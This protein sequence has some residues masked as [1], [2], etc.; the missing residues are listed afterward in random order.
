MDSV[1]DLVDIHSSEAFLDV[2]QAI[3]GRMRLTE[4]VWDQGLHSRTDEQ[5][6]IGEAFP[7]RC[8][9]R[10]AGYDGVASF[11]EK[12]QET[13]ADLGRIHGKSLAQ[14]KPRWRGSRFK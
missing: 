10:S 12:N 3:A 11:L 14:I 1:S 6:R 7:I 5:G 13:R 4:E 2:Y 8:D 9:D